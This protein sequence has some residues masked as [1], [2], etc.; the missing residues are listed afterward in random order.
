LI[1]SNDKTQISLINKIDDFG[2]S[3]VGLAN[4][5]VL[6]FLKTVKNPVARLIVA[7]PPYNIGK[8]YEKR[9]AFED[10]L[11]WQEEVLKECHRILLDNGS[12]CW[13]VGNYVEKKEIFPLDFFFYNIIKKKIGMKLRNRIIWRF[14]HGLPSSSR[15]SGRYETILWFTK[16]DDYIFNLDAVRVRSKYPGKRYYRGPNKGKPSCNIKGKNPSDI[17]DPVPEWEESVWDIPNVKAHHPEKTKHPCQFPIELIERLVLALTNES[18]LIID[19][20]CGT[21]SSLIAA[22]SRKRRAIGV[23]KSTEYINICIDRLNRYYNGSLKRRILGTPIFEPKPTD[24]VAQIPKEWEG[25]D[26]F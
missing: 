6:D 5:D 9:E 22:I 21:G 16:S 14:G 7:S 13:Q 2:N 25:L 17:W 3:E 12:L 19:P 1:G 20:F 23:D 26:H 24:K 11:D 15:F 10:Y 8:P 18:D 4:M